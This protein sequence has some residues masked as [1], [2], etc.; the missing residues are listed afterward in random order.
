MLGLNEVVAFDFSSELPRARI[1]AAINANWCSPL[2]H[3]LSPDDNF[4]GFSVNTIAADDADGRYALSVEV[5]MHPGPV[6]KIMDEFVKL[7]IVIYGLSHGDLYFYPQTFPGE[8]DEMNT[9][10]ISFDEFCRQP[11]EES[12]YY[13]RYRLCRENE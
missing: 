2:D 5:Y 8:Y 6:S 3:S 1:L 9:V 10:A 4:S 12:S 7:A 11:P 13:K